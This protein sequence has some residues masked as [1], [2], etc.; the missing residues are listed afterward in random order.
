M[1]G[2]DSGSDNQIKDKQPDEEQNLKKRHQSNQKIKYRIS[3][4]LKE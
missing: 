4:T 3:K 1:D 2:M